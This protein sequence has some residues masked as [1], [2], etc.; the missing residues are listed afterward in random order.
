MCLL[1][2]QEAQL[3][4]SISDQLATP[5]QAS[6]SASDVTSASDN[7][8]LQTSCRLHDE[9]PDLKDVSSCKEVEADVTHAHSLLSASCVDCTSTSRD[10]HE[11]AVVMV[12]HLERA[13]SLLHRTLLANDDDTVTSSDCKQTPVPSTPSRLPLP[14]SSSASVTSQTSDRAA[15]IVSRKP[16]NGVVRIVQSKNVTSSSDRVKAKRTACEQTNGS[17][18]R[19]LLLKSQR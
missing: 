9:D 8:A 6:K 18:V 16:P 5:S 19:S 17:G 11:A 14:S 10:L 1:C 7:T 13:Q 4:Q 12:Q 2:F 3:L 15:S